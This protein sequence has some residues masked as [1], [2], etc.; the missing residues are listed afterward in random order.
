VQLYG[1]AGPANVHIGNMRNEPPSKHA[2]VSKNALGY[3]FQLGIGRQW[4]NIFVTTGVGYMHTGRNVTYNYWANAIESPGVHNMRQARK[5]EDYNHVTVP[6]DIGYNIWL[7]EKLSLIPSLGVM[8]SYNTSV[9]FRQTDHINMAS[10]YHITL[11]DLDHTYRGSGMRPFQTFS[12]WGIA[13]ADLAY[14]LDSRISI[15]AGVSY[16]RMLTN[17]INPEGYPVHAFPKR[18]YNHLLS[19]NAGIRVSL[20]SNSAARRYPLSS[21][22]RW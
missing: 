7:S 15:L 21:C 5:S 16:Y 18:M 12:L 13:Q 20:T 6:L 3:H 17:M 2:S 9:R 19:F 1:G 8:G 14:S 10:V 4:G 22:G 11:F